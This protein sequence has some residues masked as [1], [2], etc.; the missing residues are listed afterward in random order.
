M[1]GFGLL[2]CFFRKSFGRSWCFAH[3]DKL[4]F[5]G[6]ECVLSVT[7]ITLLKTLLMKL[8]VACARVECGVRVVVDD[9]HLAYVGFEQFVE[10]VL[11]IMQILQHMVLADF[12]KHILSPCQIILMES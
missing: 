1:L 9:N 3:L 5:F 8:T 7:V 4:T 11:T 10:L 6:V 12:I 2:V